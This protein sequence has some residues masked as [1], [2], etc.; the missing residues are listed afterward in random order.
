MRGDADLRVAMRRGFYLVPVHGFA[1]GVE[2]RGRVLRYDTSLP[3]LVRA[4]LVLAAIR[5]V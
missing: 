4:R 3:W 5:Q 2:V 1:G